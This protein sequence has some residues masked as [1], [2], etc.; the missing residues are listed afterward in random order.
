MLCK[1]SSQHAVM[2]DIMLTAEQ[3]ATLEATANPD[4]PFG[5]QSAVVRSERSLWVDARVPYIL[6]NSLGTA[7]RRAI[8]EAINEYATRTCVRF[9]PRNSERD[10]VRFFSG[11]GYVFTIARDIIFANFPSMHAYKIIA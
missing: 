2:G 3:Q 9:V 4:D 6:D 5:A 8:Q 11:S 7:A 10:Y 1:F